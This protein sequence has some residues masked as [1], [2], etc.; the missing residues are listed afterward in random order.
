MVC[1]I[2]DRAAELSF[3]K[4]GIALPSTACRILCRMDGKLFTLEFL[5]WIGEIMQTQWGT[6]PDHGADSFLESVFCT[7]GQKESA[8]VLR[9]DRE[10]L[11]G[12]VGRSKKDA[13]RQE[14]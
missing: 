13:G 5:E 10:I 7:D 3:I 1:K 6:V 14:I 2:S 12:D 11:R 9:R 4:N 8:T